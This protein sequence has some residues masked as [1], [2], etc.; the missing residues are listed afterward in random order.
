MRW[1]LVLVE[2]T[3]S[4]LSC[5]KQV[6]EV[7]SE[8]ETSKSKGGQWAAPPA[9]IAR[10]RNFAII[11]HPDAGKTTLTEKLL[12]YGGAIQEVCINS[13]R[14]HGAKAGR[15]LCGIDS[16]CSFCGATMVTTTGNK[17]VPLCIGTKS[18][19]HYIAPSVG[20]PNGGIA[21]HNVPCRQRFTS[22]GSAVTPMYRARMSRG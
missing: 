20:N 1:Q 19:L 4:P 18:Y 6:S 5:T 21:Q 16:V 2:T 9:E 13:P 22:I 11:S 10:R 14:M 17:D 8:E 3:V 7:S 12:L 15:I